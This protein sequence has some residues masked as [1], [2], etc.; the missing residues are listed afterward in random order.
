MG[1]GIPKTLRRKIFGRFVRLGQELERENL[2]T[3]LGL[4]IVRTLIRKMKGKV[5]VQD[6]DPGPGTTFEVELPG[7]AADSD[8]A[9]R[10]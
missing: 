7:A 9:R 2:G 6:R 5:R 10:G 4:Y 1:S 3:G 8:A